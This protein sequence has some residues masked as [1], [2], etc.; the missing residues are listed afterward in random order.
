M[1]LS[2]DGLTGQPLTVDSAGFTGY[3]FQVELTPGDH[4]IGVAFLNDAY[5]P[6]VEDRNLYLDKF[7]IYSPPGIAKP[8]LASK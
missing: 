8:E 6:G 1:A 2:V 7:T 4:S 5:N 3:S